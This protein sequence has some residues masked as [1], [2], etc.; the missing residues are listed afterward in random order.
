MQKKETL[1]I[2][3]NA[4]VVIIEVILLTS[5]IIICSFHHIAETKKQK[6]QRTAEKTVIREIEYRV[7]DNKEIA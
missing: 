6:N 5:I 1:N 3:L 7:C 2:K 4:A